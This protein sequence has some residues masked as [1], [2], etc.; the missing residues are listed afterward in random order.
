[1]TREIRVS[2]LEGGRVVIVRISI[3]PV[4]RAEIDAGGFSHKRKVDR[5]C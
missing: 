1:M 2:E 5:K 4:K 3:R